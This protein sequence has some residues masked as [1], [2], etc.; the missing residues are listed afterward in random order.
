MA[1][2][3]G[4]SGR[5]SPQTRVRQ[6]PGWVFRSHMLPISPCLAPPG[7]SLCLALI[8]NPNKTHSCFSVSSSR[9]CA[10]F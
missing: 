1:A 3:F 7:G 5:W 8:S 10:C 4:P 6:R 9:P 2:F